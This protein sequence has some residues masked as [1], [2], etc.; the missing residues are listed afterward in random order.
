M[1]AD[2]SAQALALGAQHQHRRA[3][4]RA[5]RPGRPAASPARP[6]ARQ[7]R[8][9]ELV[10][11]PGEVHHAGV[12]DD[13]DGP[14]RGLGQ[15]A[16]E[17]RRVSVLDDNAAGAERCGRTEYRADVLRVGE[18]V[19]H[20]AARRPRLRQLGES[21]AARAARPSAPRPGAS[22]PGAAGGRWRRRRPFRLQVRKLRQ[23]LLAPVRRWRPAVSARRGPDLPRAASTG[24]QPQSQSDDAGAGERRGPRGGAP[25]PAFGDQA[26]PSLRR[27]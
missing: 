26:L 6:T 3:A 21:T 23:Q 10:Q 2:Q 20:H 4:R 5:P 22:H 25:R 24:C 17:G 1:F 13:V 16:G 9:V 19:Q 8:S 14:R 27:E 18:L 11:R 12:G 7:P 15:D